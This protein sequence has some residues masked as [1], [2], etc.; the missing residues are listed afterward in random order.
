MDDIVHNMV[1][2]NCWRA[3]LFTTAFSKS[4]RKTHHF[5]HNI[6][7]TKFPQSKW[8]GIFIDKS[9]LDKL[10]KWANQSINDIDSTVLYFLSRLNYIKQVW[11]LCNNILNSKEPR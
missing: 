3:A 9:N 10:A 4:A 11:K 7:K 5:S 8:I 6:A 1:D 2:I